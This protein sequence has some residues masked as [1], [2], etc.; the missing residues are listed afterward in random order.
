MSEFMPF[1]VMAGLAAGALLGC[2]YFGGLWWSV[3]RIKNIEHKKCFCFSAGCSGRSFYA[4]G[5]SCWRAMTRK[6][7]WAAPRGCWRPDF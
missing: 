5:C 1:S 2:L 4:A 6:C 3:R 7:C